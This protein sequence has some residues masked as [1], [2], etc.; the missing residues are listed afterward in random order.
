MA[1][2]TETYI[3]DNKLNHE[4]S[5]S[6]DFVIRQRLKVLFDNTKV[7]HKTEILKEETLKYAHI[8]CKLNNLSG[9]SAGPAIESYIAY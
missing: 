1:N 6:K 9:Q 7:N 8:Y 5:L 2:I 3:P 4:S